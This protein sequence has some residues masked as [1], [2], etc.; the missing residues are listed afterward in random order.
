M[1]SGNVVKASLC[2]AMLVS[3]CPQAVG[4]Q[5]PLAKPLAEMAARES[6]VRLVVTL[7]AALLVLMIVHMAVVLL[8][9]R[10]GGKVYTVDYFIKRRK[11]TIEW[12]KERQRKS[13]EEAI[14]TGS[15]L[16]PVYV[17]SEESGQEEIDFCVNRLNE[18]SDRLKTDEY[19]KSESDYFRRLKIGR[20]RYAGKRI[21]KIKDL[22]PTD[23]A[24]VER[25]NEYVRIIRKARRRGFF[26]SWFL[27]IVSV[28][29]AAGMF[30][31]NW[32][33]ASIVL[34]LA[35]VVYWLAGL[36]PH[37][38]VERRRYKGSSDLLN[39][40]LGSAFSSVV[41]LKS[42]KAMFRKKTDGE[43]A[44]GSTN[45]AEKILYL[46]VFLILCI[47]FSLLMPLWSTFNYLRNY[48]FY[49]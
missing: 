49:F 36:T 40:I 19:Y 33:E 30:M 48:V 11:K 26:G 29:L 3:A 13:S 45:F 37:Y 38:L 42:V 20:L 21:E 2:A 14:K 32:R 34:M 41:G 15:G 8:R 1:T 18:I 44:G 46:I 17:A 24:I 35:S 10:R 27:L 47:V 4:Q 7:A 28:A 16:K 25:M 22:N 5:Q 31:I 9:E 6:N 12:Q 23:V 43:E 39:G